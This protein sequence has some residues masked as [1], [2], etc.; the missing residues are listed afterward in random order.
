MAE[1]KI[2]VGSDVTYGSDPRKMLVEEIR[3]DGKAVC[4]WRAAC[5]GTFTAM[6]PDGEAEAEYQAIFP[7]E[8]SSGADR[9]VVCDD[10]FRAMAEAF[11]WD[12]DRDAA[13]LL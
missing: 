9:D 2:E 7:G 10:C 12:I 8:A 1:Q 3:E 13:R 4:G 5:R 6:R 11:D